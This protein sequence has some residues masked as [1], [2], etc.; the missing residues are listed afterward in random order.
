ML[1]WTTVVYVFLQLETE[2][3]EANDTTAKRAGKTNFNF[4]TTLLFK[5]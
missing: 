2:K 5:G 4:L 1:S 3:S